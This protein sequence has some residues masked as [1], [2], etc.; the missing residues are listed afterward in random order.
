MFLNLLDISLS[1]GICPILLYSSQNKVL[2]C[3]GQVP[4]LFLCSRV[5][6]VLLGVNNFSLCTFLLLL[7][8]RSIVSCCFSSVKSRK[9]FLNFFLVDSDI[10]GVVRLSPT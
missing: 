3:S 7:L 4:Y 10:R 6:F 8:N 9:L 2:A 5:P 1:I